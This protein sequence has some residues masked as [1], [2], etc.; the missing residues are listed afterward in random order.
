MP[1]FTTDPFT[2]V[3]DRLWALLEADGGFAARVRKGNRINLQAASS[4]STDPRRQSVQDGDLPE[5]TLEQ[6][7]G[8]V[9][10]FDTSGSAA[11]VEH[12]EVR[13]TTG[14][15]RPHKAL[16]PVKWRVLKALSRTANNLGL[17]FVR[18]VHVTAATDRTADRKLDRG[19]AGWSAVIT[20]RVEM[21][22]TRAELQA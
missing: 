6:T 3:Y 12:Y 14:D 4:G 5:V 18:H 19:T 20:V 9:D 22:V 11:I 13:I 1:D 15:P 2:Q 21:A 16:N 7:G 8:P 10:L 17:P